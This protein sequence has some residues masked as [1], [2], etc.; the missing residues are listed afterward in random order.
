MSNHFILDILF[1]EHVS[2]FDVPQQ[3]FYVKKRPISFTV[4]DDT[5]FWYALNTLC[6]Q[7]IQSVLGRAKQVS[8]PREVG[9]GKI[10]LF[11]NM[12]YRVIITSNWD[13]IL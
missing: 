4:V 11:V 3:E 5:E 8:T 2:M 1:N 7:R 13:I 6:Y 10:C 9:V 12:G